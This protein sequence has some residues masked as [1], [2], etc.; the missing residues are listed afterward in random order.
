MPFKKGQSGNPNGR[1]KR[2]HSMAEILNE[3][4]DAEKAPG[5]SRRRALM[6]QVVELAETG[7]R[8]AVE[9]VANRAEGTPVATVRTQEIDKDEVIDI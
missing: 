1:P 2:G 4:L 9:W 5:L 7:E 3:L 8:W 6:Q